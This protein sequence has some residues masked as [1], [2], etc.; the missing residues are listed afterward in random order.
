[1]LKNV[2]VGVGLVAGLLVVPPLAQTSPAAGPD[3]ITVWKASDS[4]TFDTYWEPTLNQ[5]SNY[6]RDPDYANGLAYLKI[7]V[8]AKPS[9]KTVQPAVCFWRHGDKR[10]QY[11]TCA[12]TDAVT[13]TSTGTFYVALGAPSSWW[14]KPGGW[15]WA[16]PAS[17]GR[18]MI[19]NPGTSGALL[20][21]KNCGAACYTGSDLNDHIPIAMDSELIFV[22]KGKSL[23]PPTDWQS[24]CPTAWSPLCRGG[25]GGGGG[26]PTTTTTTTTT[27]PPTGVISVPGSATTPSVRVTPS[28]TSLALEWNH[29]TAKLYQLRVKP[30]SASAYS[31]YQPSRATSTTVSGLAGAKSYTVQVRAYLNGAWQSWNTAV[32]VTG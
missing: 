2:L 27:Q 4:Q 10:F 26:T 16:T 20:L 21:G 5:P 22:A 15:T 19:K 11:E 29:P 14:V 25:G 9:S 18:I 12:R 7:N 30:T 23:T 24:G 3:Q 31:W 13:F 28:R 17:V 6:T 1:M 32:A 8:T